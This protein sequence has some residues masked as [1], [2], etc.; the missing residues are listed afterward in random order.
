MLIKD[1]LSDYED[2]TTFPEVVAAVGAIVL[3]IDTLSRPKAKPRP[4][5][6][7]SDIE[8]MEK[9]KLP[10]ELHIN[11]EP[12]FRRL[13]K[14]GFIE[15]DEFY[16]PHQIY[17]LTLEGRNFLTNWHKKRQP[18]TR[19]EDLASRLGI[20]TLISKLKPAA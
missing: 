10:A 15:Q 20:K 9:Y 11:D 4:K 17:L 14:L 16:L 2:I 5:V 7:Y 8:F 6:T 19:I 3:G 18:R 12:R 13:A 1:N